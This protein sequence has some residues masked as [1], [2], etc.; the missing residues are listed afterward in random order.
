MCLLIFLNSICILYFYGLRNLLHKY[1]WY[2]GFI[3]Y[4]IELFL[5]LLTSIL[6]PGTPEK[7]YFLENFDME[8]NDLKNY[9]I[10]GNCKLIMDLDKETEHC[11]DC[12][13]CVM[14]NDHHCPWTSKCVGYKN[15]YFFYGFITFFFILISYL[16]FA[17]MTIAFNRED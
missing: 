3:I 17:V 6:N 2:I 15:I 1:I 12:N 11:Y 8:K 16:M 5:Y 7:K 4:I 13:I 10:C 14:G 9:R